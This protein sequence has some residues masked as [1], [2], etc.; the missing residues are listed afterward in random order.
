MHV[1][2]FLK[3]YFSLFLCVKAVLLSFGLLSVVIKLVV[4]G[5]ESIT[6][7]VRFVNCRQLA[8]TFD[9]KTARFL[10]GK[11]CRKALTKR[12]VRELVSRRS[13]FA[14]KGVAKVIRHLEGKKQEFLGFGRVGTNPQLATQ[15][16]EIDGEWD[17]G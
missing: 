8:F 2:E 5:F 13:F 1:R 10:S 12:G 11:P 6:A 3:K 4:Y 14:G 7:F 15:I 17:A 9:E 16:Y